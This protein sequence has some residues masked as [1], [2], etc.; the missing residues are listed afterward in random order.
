MLEEVWSVLSQ[1]AVRNGLSAADAPAIYSGNQAGTFHPHNEAGTEIFRGKNENE[2][3]EDCAGV[4][5][6]Q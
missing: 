5:R 2:H 3:E 4:A 6:L 1:A